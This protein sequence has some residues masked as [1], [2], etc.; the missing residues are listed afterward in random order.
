MNFFKSKLKLIMISSVLAF[1]II[2]LASAAGSAFHAPPPPL[3]PGPMMPHLFADPL[4]GHLHPLDLSDEQ[5]D[6]LFEIFIEQ[7][8]AMHSAMNARI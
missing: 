1:S 6:M 4:P 8:R 3:P 7:A 2:S 5:Q